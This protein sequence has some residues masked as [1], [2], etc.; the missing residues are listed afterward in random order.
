MRAATARATSGSG[1]LGL[2]RGLL[3]RA[4]AIAACDRYTSCM[5]Y[6]SLNWC[7]PIHSGRSAATLPALFPRTD[8]R[9][10]QRQRKDAAGMLPTASE[11]GLLEPVVGVEPTT[12]CLRNR[13]MHPMLSLFR[14]FRRAKRVLYQIRITQCSAICFRLRRCTPD[15]RTDRLF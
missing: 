10:D 9:T 5:V 1:R 14:P 15:R 13:P 7:E 2:Q 4:D 11:W 3:R 6:F 12:C 8:R